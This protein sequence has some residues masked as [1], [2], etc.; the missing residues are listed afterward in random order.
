MAELGPL[1]VNLAPRG[2]LGPSR[3]WPLLNGIGS[4]ALNFARK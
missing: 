3:A 4:G 2:E 1:G